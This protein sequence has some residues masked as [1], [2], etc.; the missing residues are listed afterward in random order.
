METVGETLFRVTLAHPFGLWF[1]GDFAQAAL[2]LGWTLAALLARIDSLPMVQANVSSVSLCSTFM[3][4][5]S[6]L[7]QWFGAGE[8]G[9]SSA[10]GDVCTMHR[11][12]SS[13]PFSV[14]PW[15]RRENGYPSMSR[16]GFWQGKIQRSLLGSGEGGDK[17]GESYKC[18]TQIKQPKKNKGRMQPKAMASIFFQVNFFPPLSLHLGE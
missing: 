2:G 1:F 10:S 11:V 9:H 8:R 6:H 14:K 7:W 5:I 16:N 15:K 4:N 12:G 13:S 3:L 17:R 18:L